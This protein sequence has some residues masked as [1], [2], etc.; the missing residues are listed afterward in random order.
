MNEELG[1]RR[2]KWHR[3][4]LLALA[5]ATPVLGSLPWLAGCVGGGRTSHSGPVTDHF[6]GARFFNPGGAEPRSVL[7]VARWQLGRAGETWPDALP[8]P[9]PPDRPPQRILGSALRVSFVGHA[10]F[11]LQGAGLNILTDPV[12]SERAS[13][14]AFAGPRRVNPPGIAFD[15][16]PP[17]DVVLISHGHYDHLDLETLARLW[18][19]DQPRI[20]APLGQDATIRGHDTD[21]ALRTADW[22]DVVA[23]GNGVEAVLEQ[24][25]HWTARGVMDRNRALWCGFVIRGLGQGVFFAGDTGFDQGRPFRRVAERHGTLGLAL[26]PIGAYEPRWF[27]ADQHM[28]PADAV[29][30][31]GLLGARQALG[32][33]WGTFRL[34]DEGAEQPAADLT[35]ALAEQRVDATRFIATRPGQVWPGG[36]AS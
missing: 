34:T 29:R 18:R 32:Y 2:P 14:F 35:A 22:G 3:R 5:S 1:K 16:L 13:P 25:H 10:T 30:G 24:V 33:H 12:W 27:M 6:D 8:S 28:N 26:L 31:F 21:I 9:F 20:V 15:D 19:R 7:E 23:L 4:R 17:I 36:M 11:L